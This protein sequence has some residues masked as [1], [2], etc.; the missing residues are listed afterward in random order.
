MEEDEVDKVDKVD[1]EDF[2]ERL[3][4]HYN[5]RHCCR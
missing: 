1:I 2:L 3:K 4:S 5:R